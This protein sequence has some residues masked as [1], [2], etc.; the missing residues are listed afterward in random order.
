MDLNF[1]VNKKNLLLGYIYREVGGRL[2]CF[3]F[4]F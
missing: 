1:F 3:S 2:I 4:L